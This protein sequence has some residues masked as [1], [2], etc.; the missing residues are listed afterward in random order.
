VQ[1][2]ATAEDVTQDSF[3]RAFQ[4]MGEFRDGSF[5]AWLLKIVSN[6]AYDELRRSKRHPFISLVLEDGNGEEID[7]PGWLIDPG[8][9]VEAEVEQNE[10][11]KDIDRM[12]AELPEAQRSILTLIDRY[13]L[14]YTEAAEILHI[15]LGTVKSRL[16]RARLH[17]KRKLVGEDLL[18]PTPWIIPCS[19]TYTTP[20]SN[21]SWISPSFSRKPAG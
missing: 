21:Q 6:A 2:P 7:S 1:D 17:M 4:H 8:Q 20:M 3:V 15:P 10:L 5:R 18:C 13:E 14:D 11:S 9:S 16:A 12:L 19:P